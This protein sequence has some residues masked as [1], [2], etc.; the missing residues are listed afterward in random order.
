MLSVPTQL[1]R[2][3]ISSR[4]RSARRPATELRIRSQ[5]GGHGAGS[6]ESDGADS[7]IVLVNTTAELSRDP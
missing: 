2:D 4:S 6:V 3:R 7:L 1:G 5:R